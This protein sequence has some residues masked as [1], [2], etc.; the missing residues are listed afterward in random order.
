MKAVGVE[1]Y[2]R[3]DVMLRKD[4]QPFVLEINTILA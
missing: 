2:G 4:G 3:V 1:V